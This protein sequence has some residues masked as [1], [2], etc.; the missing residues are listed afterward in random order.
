MTSAVLHHALETVLSPASSLAR[1]KFS[2]GSMHADQLRNPD[3]FS[4]P[5]LSIQ[6]KRH[7]SSC[8]Q[9]PHSPDFRDN[10]R[11]KAGN[12]SGRP[13]GGRTRD[14]R[15][16]GQMPPEP[17]RTQASWMS[18]QEKGSVGRPPQRPRASGNDCRN[19]PLPPSAAEKAGMRTSR[20][21]GGRCGRSPEYEMPMTNPYAPPRSTHS[22]RRGAGWRSA[23]LVPFLSSLL[24]VPA[25]L[26]LLGVLRR[27]PPPVHPP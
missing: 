14:L 26:A 12:R 23:L 13:A 27:V 9:G 22:P 16:G 3:V 5:E 6:W 15:A 7:D 4:F 18:A 21:I 2:S 8:R 24:M 1:S 19:C 25:S 11:A 20:K 10:R 17:C